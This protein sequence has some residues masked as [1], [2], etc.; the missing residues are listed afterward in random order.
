LHFFVDTRV[1]KPYIL[2]MARQQ[3]QGASKMTAMI[4]KNIPRN[5]IDGK[6][7]YVAETFD[8][9]R[10]TRIQKRPTAI[11]GDVAHCINDAG[12]AFYTYLAFGEA[13]ID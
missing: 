3:T 13:S 11:G 10:V 5:E 6:D 1:N 9:V 12:E 7:G 8:R 4:F 2:F